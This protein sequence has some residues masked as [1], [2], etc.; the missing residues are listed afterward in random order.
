[1]TSAV[2]TRRDWPSL[3]AALP[4]AYAGPVGSAVMRKTP[5]DFRV[6]EKLGF[7]PTGSGEHQL[8]RIRKTG[9]NTQEIVDWL[10][11]C[12]GIKPMDVGFCGLK[13]KQA[14][15]DQ[16]FSLYLPG[17][18]DISLPVENGVEILAQTRHNRKLRRGTHQGN[19]FELWLRD[20]DGEPGQIEQRLACIRARGFPNYF[21]E[22]RFGI[23]F[24]NLDRA[25]AMFRGEL[26]RVKRNQKSLYLSAARSWLFNK[27][28]AARLLEGSWNRAID[29]ERFILE[30]SR[31][32]FRAEDAST[33]EPRLAA[34]DIH[35]SGPLWGR[36]GESDRDRLYETESAYL[37]EEDEFRE[38]LEQAGLKMERRPLR[39]LAHE[40]DWSWPDEQTL[41]LTFTLDRGC[42]AT[43]LLREVTECSTG[44]NR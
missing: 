38:G 21:A 13:D 19:Q 1:M 18:A 23:G 14:E 42:F 20:C 24:N 4:M 25:R 12:A 9:R 32:F 27:V 10:A 29:D 30:G 15:T 8:L 43:S 31:S 37:R 6:S 35:T 33:E 17:Q 26:R 7:E 2:L 40:L 22:Q 39:T 5:A 34:L 16:W 41:R 36:T 3:F 44:D 11:R 28:C